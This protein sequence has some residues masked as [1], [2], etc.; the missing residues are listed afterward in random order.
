[1]KQIRA[2]KYILLIL[3][4]TISLVFAFFATLFYMKSV[5]RATYEK[6]PKVTIRPL[7]RKHSSS[8]GNELRFYY[9][10]TNNEAVDFSKLSLPEGWSY[11]GTFLFYNGHGQ[12]LVLTMEESITNLKI[13][14]C[15]QNGSGMAEVLVG[16]KVFETIDLYD[17]DWVQIDFVIELITR[18]ELIIFG[19]SAGVFVFFLLYI[20]FSND[21]RSDAKLAGKPR[22]NRNTLGMFDYAKGIGILLVIIFH[23]IILFDSRQGALVL[24][25]GSV[26]ALPRT[27]LVN[28]LM[29]AFIMISGYGMKKTS[30]K[31]CISS[32]SRLLLLP[33]LYVAAAVSLISII[34]CLITGDSLAEMLQ[35]SISPF[36][37]DAL[38]IG[39]MWFVIALYFGTILL[40]L[41]LQ[42]NHKW[43]N[44]FLVFV[45]FIIGAV[46]WNY[47]WIPY[48]VTISF[49]A[50]GY[51]YFG[52][53]LK[54]SKW[55]M[56]MDRRKK[57][58]IA[59]LTCVIILLAVTFHHSEALPGLLPV[60]ELHII[61]LFSGFILVCA[62]LWLN[63]FTDIF[64]NRIRVIGRYSLWILCIHSIEFLCIPW[65]DLT[66]LLGYRVLP[67]TVLT[68]VLRASLSFF[69]CYLLYWFKRR[70]SHAS[71]LHGSIIINR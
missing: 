61:K 50:V 45:T 5:D 3:M 39:P 26:S 24:Q 31:K 35:T 7:D 43:G 33:Y 62:A 59:G 60:F 36:L 70:K 8:W 58:F 56:V 38:K 57:A 55:L 10:M 46:T 49:T 20:V 42:W 71:Q 63:K 29:P 66:Q 2:N 6:E 27:L 21:L 68:I 1:M 12:E 15:K 22:E 52:Y 16:D 47:E 18:S 30:M 64:S 17:E 9:I 23:S 41:I 54:K 40:N 14:C 51:A 34:R 44:H 19:L 13:K 4:L 48:V 32:L 25:V 65:Q 37:T 28:G 11:D 67:I 69:A 53:Y